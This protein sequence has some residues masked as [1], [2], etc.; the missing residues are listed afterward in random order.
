LARAD[1]GDVRRLTNDPA[2]DASSAWSPDGSRI[3]F[4]SARTGTSELHLVTADCLRVERLTSGADA[5]SDVPRWSPDGSYVAFQIAEGNR[6]DIGLLRLRDRQQK[7]L[8]GTPDNDGSYTWS[9]DGTRLAY[10]SGRSG[11]EILHV[12]DVKSY[13]STRI[14]ATWSLTPSW[15]R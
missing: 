9:P 1:G 4:V 15:T 5:S 6:Y 3:L 13:T 2:K 14:T 12:I 11:A 8:V 7:V 10:I